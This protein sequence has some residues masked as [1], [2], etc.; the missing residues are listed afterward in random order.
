M[1]YLNRQHLPRKNI[2]F[3]AAAVN[4]KPELITGTMYITYVHGFADIFLE[5]VILFSPVCQCFN[6]VYRKDL[7]VNA[8]MG[9]TY[10]VLIV[11]LYRNVIIIYATPWMKIHHTF[12]YYT[13]IICRFLY[14]IITT[15]NCTYLL[16]SILTIFEDVYFWK[17]RSYNP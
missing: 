8:L 9:M 5:T 12:Y 10:I 2:H 11:L 14:K 1:S 16:I 4:E 3:L 6:I 17:Q 13:K 15:I 7:Q